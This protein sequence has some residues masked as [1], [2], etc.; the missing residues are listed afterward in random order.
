MAQSPE[1]RKELLES[2]IIREIVYQ[3]AQKQGL[4]KSP[5]F[6]GADG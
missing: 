2:M 4:D 5:E 6:T 3:D 1:G